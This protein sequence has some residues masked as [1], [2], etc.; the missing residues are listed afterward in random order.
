MASILNLTKKLKFSQV[1]KKMI[2]S[3]RSIP[4]QHFQ[5]LSGE[6]IKK[7]QDNHYLWVALNTFENLLLLIILEDTGVFCFNWAI[8]QIVLSP[9]A[10]GY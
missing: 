3:C 1:E 8:I 5:S 9:H 6:I 10:S 7:I 4:A 2:M